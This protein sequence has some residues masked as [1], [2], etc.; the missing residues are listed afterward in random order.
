LL[1]SYKVPDHAAISRLCKDYLS[2][3]VV[4][5]LFYRQVNYLANQNEMLF[6]NAFIDG[7][8]IEA[9]DNR[10]TFVWKKAI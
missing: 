5:D 8:K 6:E 9:N 10:Y 4:E 1:Q 7:T 3:E 2:N